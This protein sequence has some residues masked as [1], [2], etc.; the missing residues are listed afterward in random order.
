[1][2]KAELTTTTFFLSFSCCIIHDIIEN[3]GSLFRCLTAIQVNVPITGE[4]EAFG[5]INLFVVTRC[6]LK[7][8]RQRNF[9]ISVQAMNNGK[10]G[11]YFPDKYKYRGVITEDCKLPKVDK[12]VILDLLTGRAY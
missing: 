3:F 8:I 5:S 10:F 1:M 2:A 9:I 7:F 11:F 6:Y 4:S 12:P